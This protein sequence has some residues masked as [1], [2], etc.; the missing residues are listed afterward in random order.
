VPLLA[1]RRRSAIDLVVL[2]HPHPDHYQ[3]LTAVL[4]AVAVKEV[5]DSGQADGEAERSGTAAQA[6]AWLRQAA[7]KG[8]VVRSPRELCGKPR[9]YAGAKLEVLWPCPEYDPGYDP[10]D[11][12]LVVRVSFGAHRLLF[13]GDIEAHAEAGLVRSGESLRANVLKVPHHGSATSS[14]LEL[15]RAVAPELAVISAGAVNRF[16]HPNPDVVAR[17]RATGA[18]VIELSRAGGTIVSSDG[19]ELRV[20]P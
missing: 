11:N 8:A 12:S 20:E 7:A 9:V 10:N 2:S 14:S 19:K 17:L 15:L 4:N 16:G 5:W 1:A 6:R 18:R 3:G 13:A